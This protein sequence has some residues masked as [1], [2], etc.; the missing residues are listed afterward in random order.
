MQHGQAD[1]IALMPVVEVEHRRVT[2]RRRLCQ[3]IHPEHTGPRSP[4][5]SGDNIVSAGTGGFTRLLARHPDPLAEFESL[6]AVRCRH[7]ES[8][9]DFLNQSP[10][11]RSALRSG[12]RLTA[13]DADLHRDIVQ[14]DTEPLGLVE[15]RLRD[16][17]H[18]RRTVLVLG[19]KFQCRL[20]SFEESAADGL[21]RIGADGIDPLA[22]GLVAGELLAVAC[23]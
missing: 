19:D 10:H 3:R 9:V 18:E 6:D 5:L 22:V 2:L 12:R 16:Q 7:I 20:R 21:L 11:R 14:V 1:V 15:H 17:A 8:T 4:C 23:H 13:E